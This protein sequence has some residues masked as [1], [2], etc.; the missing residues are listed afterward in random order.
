MPDILKSMEPTNFDRANRGRESLL[1]TYNDVFL[2]EE[3]NLFS[4]ISD[5]I[6][7]LLHLARQEGLIPEQIISLA[8]LHFRAEVDEEEDAR[9]G[10]I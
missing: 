6:A 7:D 5:A 8:Q 2:A 9:A 1:A 4:A 10:R 3:G